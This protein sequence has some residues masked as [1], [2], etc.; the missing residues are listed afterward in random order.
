LVKFKEDKNKENPPVTNDISRNKD[1]K[2]LNVY[3]HRVIN[4]DGTTEEV[5]NTEYWFVT[6]RKYTDNNN[7]RKTNSNN[8]KSNSIGKKA[9]NNQN[10]RE[11]YYKKNAKVKNSPFAMLE[12]LKKNSED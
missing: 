8:K 5:L 12:A 4:K 11:Q 1:V 3:H 6:K 7:T 2:K 10:N 9:I